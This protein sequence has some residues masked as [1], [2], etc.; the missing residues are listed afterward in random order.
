MCFC[1][2]VSLLVVI[3]SLLL[4]FLSPEQNLINFLTLYSFSLDLECS[5]LHKKREVLL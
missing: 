5:Y 3:P 2:M 4:H 1:L